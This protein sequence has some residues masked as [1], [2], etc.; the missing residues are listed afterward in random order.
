M[1]A[2]CRLLEV[3]SFRSLIRTTA[4]GADSVVRQHCLFGSRRAGRVGRER[5]EGAWGGDQRLKLVYMKGENSRDNAPR[6][7]NRLGQVAA[8][9]AAAAVGERSCSRF[10]ASSLSLRPRFR[11]LRISRRR[12]RR[13]V[14]SCAAEARANGR[15]RL[16]HPDTITAGS[17][18]ACAR[19]RAL[20][21]RSAPVQASSQEHGA[22]RS[23]L[24]LAI[25]RRV[26]SRPKGRTLRPW[27]PFGG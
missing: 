4:S 2:R 27:R 9:T 23:M 10:V 21:P 17:C 26:H 25:A 19:A 3:E 22:D 13:S 20:G 16:G 18:S 5:I 8:A 14:Y 1:R 24:Q 11:V 7:R 15:R 6:S 12:S